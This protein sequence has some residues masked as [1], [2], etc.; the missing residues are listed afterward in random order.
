M[1]C[2]LH[3][4]LSFV[5]SKES[6]WVLS[7]DPASNKCGVSL[8][9]NGIYIDSCLLSSISSS[10][11]ISRRMQDILLQF[12][13][14][15]AGNMAAGDEINTIVTEGVRSRIVGVCIGSFLVCKTIQANLYSKGSFVEPQQWKKWAKM[16]GASGDVIKGVKALSEAGWDMKKFPV[17]SDDVADSILIYLC[18]RDRD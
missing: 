17:E 2:L 3:W 8:W 10:D 4:N 11:P 18:W 15:L 16:R 1:L 9:K 5:K 13:I 12:E 7:V 6:G 14:F